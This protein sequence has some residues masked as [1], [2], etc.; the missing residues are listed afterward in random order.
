V[1]VELVGITK[2]FG[3]VRANDGVDLVVEPGELVGVLGENGAGKSTLMKILSG[4]QPADSGRISV[5]GAPITLGSP[6]DAVAAGIGML[7]QDPLVFLPMTVLENYLLA[8]PAEPERTAARVDLAGAAE[9]FGFTLDADTPVRRLS[10]GERQ[11]LEILR[12]ISQG[13]R[14]LIL[15]EPTTAISVTQRAALFAALRRLAADGTSVVFVSHKLDEVEELCS[16]VVVMRAGR[17][18]GERPVPWPHDELVELMFG[19][20][21]EPEVRQPSPADASRPVVRLEAVTVDDPLVPLRPVD[22]EVAAGESLG[23][24]GLEGSGQRQLLRALAGLLPFS[25][26]RFQLQGAD[27]T[28]SNY[29]HRLDAGIRFLPANRIEE[30]LVEGMSITELVALV[31]PGGAFIDWSGAE[32]GAA[33]RVDRYSIKGRAETCCEELSG[34]NQ[35]RLMFAL[36]P[37]GIDLLLMEHPTRG[38]DLG[39]ARWVWGTL[40][41][42]QR[43]GTAIVFASSDMDELLLHADRIAVFYA[44]EIIDVVDAATV[45]A[46]RLGGLM[47]GMGRAAG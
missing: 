27:V 33:Q 26:G 32:Q 4:F 20:R 23:L 22:L 10:V 16:R 7:H 43:R 31:E 38:L 47:A 45:G 13:A 37:E 1:T 18:V 44:G 12:L 42:R 30:G 8:N 5:D 34:G 25:A 28:H 3:S 36:L 24:A 19:R 40:L 39:S 41:E 6:A 29:H 21:V 35:Q 46:D 17:V 14:V 2:T 15:D 9:R 11:Q